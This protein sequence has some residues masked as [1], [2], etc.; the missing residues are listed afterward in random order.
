LLAKH[1]N[2]KK[3]TSESPYTYPKTKLENCFTLKKIVL[4]QSICRI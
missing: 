3:E 4:E 1:H 2:P